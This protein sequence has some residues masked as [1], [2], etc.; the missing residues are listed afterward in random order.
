[1]DFKQIEAFVYVVRHKSFSKAADALYLTQPTISSHISSLE[2]ILGIKLIDRSSKEIYPTTAGKIF[3]EYAQNLINMR[4][5]AIYALK[6]FSTNIKGKLEIAASTVPSQYI[7]PELI[8]NFLQKYKNINFNLIQLDT[9]QVIEELIDKKF[10]IGI[11]GSM[12]KND[13]LVYEKLTKDKLVLITPCNKKYKDMI[14]KKI[15]INELINEPFIFRE[16]GSGTRQEF[17]K[18]LN[19]ANV[20]PKSIKIIAQINNL[21]AIK[22]AVHLGL[23]VSIVSA[24]SA[25]DYLK[26]GMLKVFEI[27]GFTMKREFYLVHYKNR[28][29]SPITKAFKSFALK[30]Y[31]NN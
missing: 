20:N 22:Q 26:S 27:E 13:K 2:N 16:S 29:I 11:V 6:D 5:N 7:V 23:G 30:Y 12:I 10:E 4:D 24:R 9:G 21:E 18:F 28:P 8:I 17:E 3:F 19:K 15:S 14:N 1:M 25:E 31:K